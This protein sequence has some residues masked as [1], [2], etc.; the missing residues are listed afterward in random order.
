MVDRS[1]VVQLRPWGQPVRLHGY[2]GASAVVIMMCFSDLSPNLSRSPIA[3][4]LPRWHISFKCPFLAVWFACYFDRAKACFDGFHDAWFITRVVEGH[5]LLL[6][7]SGE[8]YDHRTYTQHS[9]NGLVGFGF[10][11]GKFG[12]EV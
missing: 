1:C 10:E 11:A 3:I 12:E 5:C 6:L 4:I 9:S 8:G 2:R 7:L